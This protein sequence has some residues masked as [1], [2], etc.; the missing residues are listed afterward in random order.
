MGR[1]GP[2]DVHLEPAIQH[3]AGG[4]VRHSE[5]VSSHVAADLYMLVEELEPPCGGFQ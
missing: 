4:Y 2:G 1:V 5:Q 3:H